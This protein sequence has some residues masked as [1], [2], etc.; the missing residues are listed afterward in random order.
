MAA[1]IY[2]PCDPWAGDED[3]TICGAL[4]PDSEGITT[5]MIAVASEWLWAL[6]ARQF[7]TCTAVIRPTPHM[8]V[9]D[10]AWMSLSTAL[11][12]SIGLDLAT[13]LSLIFRGCSCSPALDLGV[14]P[15][16]T[17]NEVLIDG[18]P[19]ADFV[20]VDFQYLVRT[21]GHAWPS[22]DDIAK[23]DTEV[24]T[25]SVDV[26]YGQPVPFMGR[27]AVTVLARELVLACLS[28]EDE[29]QLPRHV[30]QVARQGMTATILDPFEM[31]TNGKLG[32]YEVDAF[33]QT[34]NPNGLQEPPLVI[35]PGMTPLSVRYT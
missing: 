30:Q 32:I 17:I 22:C 18:V 19:F 7:G 2:G 34:T 25:W 26:T 16:Q 1:P 8:A 15:I 21:D 10:T 14:Y 9:C 12:F 11:P 24:G 27:Y 20:V 35:I 4:P 29:C 5:Q 33:I 13:Q 3:L 28:Q 6:T 23:P 31:L